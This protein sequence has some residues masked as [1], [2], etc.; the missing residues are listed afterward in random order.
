MASEDPLTTLPSDPDTDDAS[1]ASDPAAEPV[2]VP[3][4]RTTRAVRAVIVILSVLVVAALGIL[5][6]FVVQLLEARETIGDQRE[7]ISELNEIIDTKE[8]FGAAMGELMDTA[9]LLDGAPMAAL[10][11]FDDFERIARLAWN[12]RR[13]PA[14]LEQHAARAEARTAELREVLERSEAERSSNSTKTLPERVLDSLG[15]GFASLV[16]DDA[17][18]LCGTDV[19]GC[20]DGSDPYLVHLD[21]A[22]LAHPSVDDWGRRYI[23]LHEYAHVLQYT[24]PEATATAAESFR[25]DWEFMA[26]CY[27]L[28]ALNSRSLERRVWV[29]AYQYWDTSYGYGR[30]CNTAQRRVIDDWIGDVG[31]HYRAV[32]Q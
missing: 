8:T 23:A 30:V 14:R 28:N 4:P 13:S 24:N 17:D 19:L 25:G 20:V 22:D 2:A 9:R 26:D 29:S 18:A 7:E 10:V 27:A 31:V 6:Y 1:A 15:D 21:R 12:D 5:A 11:P 3:P 32:S 16:Y